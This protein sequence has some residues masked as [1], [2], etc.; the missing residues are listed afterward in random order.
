[1]L[2]RHYHFAPAGGGPFVQGFSA[3][4]DYLLAAYLSVN[5]PLDRSTCDGLLRLRHRGPAAWGGRLL[6]AGSIRPALALCLCHRRGGSGRSHPHGGLATA[7]GKG[8]K[9]TRTENEGFLAL[10]S[11]QELR[12]IFLVAFGS[13][14]VFSSVFKLPAVYLSA[15]PFNASTQ[16]ITLLYLSY[17]S[18][19]S[20]ARCPASSSNRIGN[21]GTMVLGSVIF[22]LA[23]ALTL[24]KSLAA[25]LAALALVC[26]GFFAIHAAA[27]GSL[28]RKLTS[29]RPGQSLYV[30]AYYLGAR[31]HHPERLTYHL[32]GWPRGGPGDRH[33]GPAVCHRA[34]GAAPGAGREA[35]AE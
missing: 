2:R 7:G 19:S 12:R 29:S 25:I 17:S 32:A 21:G 20:S 11:H 18:G 35:D 6:G 33:A 24:I 26:A 8:P 27:A 31:R 5:L 13:I 34:G 16:L 9:R 22:A 14:F 23:L 4:F 10:L 28:N 30:L 15:P 1:M 3:G